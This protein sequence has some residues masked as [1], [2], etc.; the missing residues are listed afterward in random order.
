MSNVRPLLASEASNTPDWQPMK[1]P[2]PPEGENVSSWSS[3]QVGNWLASIGLVD[4]VPSFQHHRVTGDVLEVLSEE[5]LRELGVALVGHRV[6][7]M[8]EVA[9][10]RRS[11]VSRQRFRTIWKGNEVLY[12][13][14]PFDWLAQQ[15]CC[16]PCCLEPDSYRLTGSTFVLVVRDHTK[17]ARACCPVAKETRIVD[18][19]S[20]VGVSSTYH[21]RCFECGCAADALHLDLN[22]ELGLASVPVLYIEKGT[23]QRVAQEIQAAMEE[24]QAYEHGAPQPQAIAGR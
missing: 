11:A 17:R 21:S 23:G 13:A 22:H 8:R 7:L 3:H 5:H 6:L 10:M 4:Y 2:P 19:S 9:A 20:V 24:A 15:L 16:V 12:R 18:L 14:G 1:L